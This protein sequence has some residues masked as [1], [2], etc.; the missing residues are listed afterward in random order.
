MNAEGRSMDAAA[1]KV[2]KVYRS[3]RTRRQ[4]ADSAVVSGNAS[5]QE[6]EHYEYSTRNGKIIHVKSGVLLDT[7]IG[8]GHPPAKFIFVMC[9]NK[10]LYGGVKVSADSGHYRPTDENLDIFL[11]FLRE[12]GVS[13]DE[14]ERIDSKSKAQP[15]QL[16]HQLSLKWCSG[17][18][19]RIG[20]V[21]DYPRELRFQALEFVNL[22]PRVSSTSASRSFP[23]S[24]LSTQCS[25]PIPDFQFPVCDSGAA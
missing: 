7:T 24:P 10:K 19:P 17:V 9:T 25:T 8:Q 13:L 14:V 2:Q 5:K 15:Y 3:Y 6:R 12:N 4:L 20:C 23:T 18:G 22:S 1:L 21:A 11:E 16:G